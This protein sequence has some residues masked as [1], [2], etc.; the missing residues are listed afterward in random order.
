MFHALTG[1]DKGG[2]EKMKQCPV[3]PEYRCSVTRFYW[4]HCRNCRKMK[5]VKIHELNEAIGYHRR[6]IDDLVDRV[7]KLEDNKKWQTKL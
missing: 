2:S 7:K 1:E 4:W 3:D 5:V 6:R